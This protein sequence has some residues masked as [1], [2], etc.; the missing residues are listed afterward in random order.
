[1]K[2]VSNVHM[3]QWLT[4]NGNV[5]TRHGYTVSQIEDG[6]IFFLF[7]CTPYCHFSQLLLLV[8]ILSSQFT[9]GRAAIKNVVQ[10]QHLQSSVLIVTRIVKV[11][12]PMNILVEVRMKRNKKLKF[13]KGIEFSQ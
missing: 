8:F 6:I 1:M 9:Q 13:H 3:L 2:H 10:R 7:L 12:I 4:F 11:A 5:V